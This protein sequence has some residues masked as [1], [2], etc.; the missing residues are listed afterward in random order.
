LCITRA[1]FIHP[2]PII[3]YNI[4]MSFKHRDIVKKIASLFAIGVILFSSYPAII[5]VRALDKAALEAELREIEKQIAEYEKQLKDTR[6]EKNTLN[7]KINQLRREQ[8][9]LNLQIKSTELMIDELQGKIGQT[10][11]MIEQNLQKNKELQEQISKA[12]IEINEQDGTAL[13][14][15][16]AHQDGLSGFFT[17]IANYNQLTES[18]AGTLAELKETKQEYEQRIGEM[19]SHQEEA[20]K[21]ISIKVLEQAGLNGKISE[22]NVLLS[23]TKGKESAYAE[24]LRQ[25][26]RKASEIR[27]Q[28][29]DVIG[30]NRQVTFGEA[31]DIAVGVSKQTGVRAAFLLAILTQESNLGKNVGTCNR[32]G[33]P[34][35]KSY[36]VVMKPTRDIEPFLKITAELGLD[37][38]T[39]PVSCPMRDKYG[40]QIGYGGAMGPAQFIPSTWVGYKDRVSAITGRP[41]NPWDI[42]DAFIA[43]ALLLKANGAT[44]GEDGEWKAAMRYFSGGTNPAYRFYGDN[45]LKTAARYQA[46]IDAIQAQ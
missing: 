26:Q 27:A 22:Q 9:A 33:D 41:A 39:T 35:E 29:Y 1:L 16:L 20:Q 11:E 17:E 34:P 10:E 24:S 45:V 43:A 36:R 46:D 42:R 37:P 30:V 13:V 40:K 19:D 5:P 44:G 3:G 21:L 8:N 15:A 7:S 32:A 31:M 2:T 14:A 12:I 6:S 25:S 23:Q 18:L 38:E 4:S 28:I